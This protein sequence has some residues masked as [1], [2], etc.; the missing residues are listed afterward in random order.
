MVNSPSELSNLEG[1]LCLPLNFIM[2]KMKK[3]QILKAI[4]HPKL[5]PWTISHLHNLLVAEVGYVHVR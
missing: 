1:T 3:T 5:T 2:A 4:F